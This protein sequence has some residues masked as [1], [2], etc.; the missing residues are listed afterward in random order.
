[1]NKNTI[2]KIKLN[3]I[4]YDINDLSKASI[5]SVEELTSIST[6]NNLL[7]SSA[8]NKI[9]KLLSN[10]DGN[11]QSI[12]YGY[13][14]EYGMFQELDLSSDYII[15]PRKTVNQLILPMSECSPLGLLKQIIRK[16]GKS[17][18]KYIVVKN[19]Q[20]YILFPVG[21][22]MYQFTLSLTSTL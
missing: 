17:N 2:S 16:N 20:I 19:K 14:N 15:P 1:M 18:M 5:E 13:I 3:G 12:Q 10:I 8:H 21:K 9:N 4:I 11:S 7:L 6:N 22:P